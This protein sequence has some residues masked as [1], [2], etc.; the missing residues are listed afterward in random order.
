MKGWI[1]YLQQPFTVVPM[2][3]WKI[4]GTALLTVVFILGVFRP[5]GIAALD[6]PEVLLTLALAAAGT[7]GGLFITLYLLPRLFKNYYVHWT[8]G[9]NILSNLLTVFFVGFGNGMVPL[10]FQLILTGHLP[11]QWEAQFL[12]FFRAVLLVSPFPVVVTAFMEQ[13]QSLKKH[14]DEAQEMSR[15]LCKQTLPGN[16]PVPD[17]PLVTLTGTTKESVGIRPD[18]LLYLEACGNYVQVNYYREGTVCRKII[19]TTLKQMEDVL[20]PYPNLLRC[21]RAFLVNIERVREAKGNSQGYRLKLLETPVE[22]PVSRAYTSAVRE[23]IL[24]YL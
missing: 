16:S 20:Q 13:N 2:P 3:F 5:F 9:K 6:L 23:H 21:H 1:H 10:L 12:Y 4:A 19:R 11:S 22:I 7:I 8:V 14:L 15:N 17:T 18:E 24:S